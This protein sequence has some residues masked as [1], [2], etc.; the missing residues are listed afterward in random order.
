MTADELADALEDAPEDAV[1]GDHY[2]VWG[3]ML[4]DLQT[5]INNRVH[6]TT[7]VRRKFNHSSIFQNFYFFFFLFLQFRP[8][9]L[10]RP[11][12]A[13]GTPRDPNIEYL[14]IEKHLKARD[15]IAKRA[16]QFVKLSTKKIH[17][18]RVGTVG[19]EVRFLVP[20]FKVSTEGS[21]DIIIFIVLFAARC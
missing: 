5:H 7:K 16:E 19:E 1:Y 6:S 20:S 3:P 8:V 9:D 10:F 14:E 12:Y 17:R 2:F 11:L 4:P 13:P 18:D 21:F 15:N